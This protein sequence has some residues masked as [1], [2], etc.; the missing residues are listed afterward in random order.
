[1]GDM[2]IRGID[3]ELKR[4]LEDRA[5]Q[6]GR[7]LSDEAIGLLR[8]GLATRNASQE[9]AGDRLY[10]LVGGAVFTEEELKSLADSRKEIDR[11]PPDLT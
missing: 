6:N 3:P 9:K 4:R 8:K 5:R 7:S 2:L 11:P 1:M 10:G